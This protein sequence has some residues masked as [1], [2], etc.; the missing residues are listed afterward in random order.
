MD[1]EIQVK[2]GNTDF[3]LEAEKVYES[4]QIMRI[5]VYGKT[6]YILLEND[7]PFL[8]AKG[9]KRAVKWKVRYSDFDSR[10]V[11]KDAKLIA[12]IISR[13]D[14]ELKGVRKYF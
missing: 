7:Y 14:R 5:K 4:S 10:D 13:L 9:S 1:W 6:N 3:T 8:F 12:D 2:Y 11:Q